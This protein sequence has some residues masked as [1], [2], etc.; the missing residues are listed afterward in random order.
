VAE[1]W[2]RTP[3]VPISNPGKDNAL[4]GSS[5]ACLWAKPHGKYV[6]TRLYFK[7]EQ[8]GMLFPT[9]NNGFGKGISI[10]DFL[11]LLTTDIS[12]FSDMQKQ[13]V[14]AFLDIRG[15]YDMISYI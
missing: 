12:T 5:F 14:A 7:T 1:S 8:N 10:R 2:Y 13:T 15:T 9:H 11:A 3:L 6:F 4:S